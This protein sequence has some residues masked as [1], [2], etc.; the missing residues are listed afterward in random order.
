[1]RAE[2]GQPLPS[3]RRT[4]TAAGGPSA[5]PGGMTEENDCFPA[6]QNPQ[7]GHPAGKTAAQDRHLRSNPCMLVSAVCRD[8]SRGLRRSR[9]LCLSICLLAADVE[10]CGA[11]PVS[12]CLMTHR[13][14]ALR[15]PGCGPRWRRRAR[16]TRCCGLSWMPG[17][18]CGGG[19]NCGWRSWSVGWG[20]TAP[21]R[22]RLP[23]R[24]GSGRR[25][26]GWPGGSPSGS[27]ARTARGAASPAIRARA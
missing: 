10:A 15:T 12:R 6:P 2:A 13:D 19:W 4:R 21:T 26:P 23:R 1:M 8:F 17:G 22:G 27:A 18:S 20:W 5:R 14:F 9:L 11:C 24:S 25:R 7:S 16:R 3:P